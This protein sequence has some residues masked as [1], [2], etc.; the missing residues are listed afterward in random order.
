MQNEKLKK[1]KKELEGLKNHSSCIVKTKY[2]TTQIDYDKAAMKATEYLCD[3]YNRVRFGSIQDPYTRINHNLNF[4]YHHFLMDNCREAVRVGLISGIKHNY[5]HK[6]DFAV[7]DETIEIRGFDEVRSSVEQ[8]FKRQYKLSLDTKEAELR[9]SI[10]AYNKKTAEVEDKM[11]AAHNAEMIKLSDEFK[12]T[13]ED[14]KKHIEDLNIQ[15][16]DKNKIINDLSKSQEE[17]EREAE[18][19][20]QEAIEELERI[21]GKKKGFFSRLFS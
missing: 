13:E 10:N 6:D 1:L 8:E 16:K 9:D 12:K 20:L 17:K 3:Q 14:Y 21:K 15:I 2:F 4:D 11:R 7:G 5:V 18:Q 19:K